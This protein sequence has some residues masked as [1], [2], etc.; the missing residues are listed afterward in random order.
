MALL[1]P[2]LSLQILDSSPCLLSTLTKELLEA[3]HK[4]RRAELQI[5]S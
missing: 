5:Q 2:F 4:Q 1:P 3:L